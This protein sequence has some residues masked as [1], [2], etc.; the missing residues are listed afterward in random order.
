MRPGY[1]CHSA[2]DNLHEYMGKRDLRDDI[3]SS[4]GGGGGSSWVVAASMAGSGPH[5]WCWSFHMGRGLTGSP[6]LV[7]V[8]SCDTSHGCDKF[9]G[10][11]C[12]APP[13]GVRCAP[14]R[15]NTAARVWCC[16]CGALTCDPPGVRQDLR[17]H[18]TYLTCIL[19]IFK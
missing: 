8:M 2:R 13:S 1:D 11:P 16:T 3:V 4:L 10:R 6:M 14:H 17:C 7:T 12:V 18:L 9:N 19:Q 5:G 15:G